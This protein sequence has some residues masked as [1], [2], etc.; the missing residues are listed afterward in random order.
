M[1]EEGRNRKAPAFLYP[2]IMQNTEE[3]H[4]LQAADTSQTQTSVIFEY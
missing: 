2:K 1:A 3:T 4:F